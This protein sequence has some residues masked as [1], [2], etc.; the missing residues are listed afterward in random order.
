ME[1]IVGGLVAVV[2]LCLVVFFLMRGTL[3]Q[4]LE[5]LELNEAVRRF[6]LQ[7]E[8]LEHRF[9]QLAK[10]NGKPRGLRWVECDWQNGVSF[11][12]DLNN[13][14]L[15][16]FVAINVHFEAVEGGGMEEVEAVSTVRD[17]AAVF[18]YQKGQW[19]TGGRC[20]FNM[21]PADA[22]T[23]LQGQYEPVVESEWR[24]E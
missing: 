13:G 4:R 15:T 5:Q 1:W 18:H 22:V 6:R 10:A 12:R 7:R 14:L 20:L 9:F 21:N 3:G 11:A 17:A 19:G 24:V 23:R 8:S 16:A 2:V